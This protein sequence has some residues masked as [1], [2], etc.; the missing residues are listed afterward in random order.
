MSIE[1][2]EDLAGR[3]EC[4]Q[5]LEPVVRGCF[6]R[7]QCLACGIPYLTNVKYGNSYLS[8]G[9]KTTIRGRVIGVKGW[10]WRGRWCGEIELACYWTCC[11]RVWRKACC[12]GERYLQYSGEWVIIDGGR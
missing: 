10:N 11:G 8:F 1:A 9:L 7:S 3:P 6:L 2:A 4:R 5:L 12:V